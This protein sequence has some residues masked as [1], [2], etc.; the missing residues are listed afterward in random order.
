MNS[1][2]EVMRNTVANRINRKRVD[3]ALVITPVTPIGQ[4]TTTNL[5]NGAADGI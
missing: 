5:S 4:K 1:A 2:H 3:F